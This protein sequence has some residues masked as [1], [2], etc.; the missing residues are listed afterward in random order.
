MSTIGSNPSPIHSTGL[1]PAGR[2]VSF[3]DLRQQGLLQTDAGL[4]LPEAAPAALVDPG[5]AVLN[6]SAWGEGD[7]SRS[8]PRSDAFEGR[9]AALDRADAAGAG[10]D[11]ILAAL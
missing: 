2:Q 9:L 3:D 6:L 10:V 7:A 11:G 5:E 4:A 8:L 1:D